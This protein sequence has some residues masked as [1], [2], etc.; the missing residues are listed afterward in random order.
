[1]ASFASIAVG[2]SI[3]QMVKCRHTHSHATGTGRGRGAAGLPL[4]GGTPVLSGQVVLLSFRMDMPSAN[5][6]HLQ[7]L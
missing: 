7:R 5:V 6:C 1:M 4:P 3:K 2:G